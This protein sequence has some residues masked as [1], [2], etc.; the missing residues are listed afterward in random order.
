MPCVPGVKSH[1]VPNRE[2]DQDINGIFIGGVV[3]AYH[4]RVKQ[5]TRP[6]HS[7]ERT[8]WLDARRSFVRTTAV[9]SAVSLRVSSNS[10]HAVMA[11]VS[12][13]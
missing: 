8:F 4:D 13:F 9:K 10:E 7:R 11:F 6:I 3:L 1:L 12:R 2:N 5:A